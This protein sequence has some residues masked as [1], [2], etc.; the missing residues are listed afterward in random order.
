MSDPNSPTADGASEGSVSSF[1]DRTART[2]A[3]IEEL[4]RVVSE[5][6]SLH[7]GRKFSPDGH[8]VGSIGEAAAEAMFDLE[9]KP[10]SNKGFDAVAADGRTVEIKA[11]F[12]TSGVGVRTFSNDVAD[13]LIVLRLMTQP[14]VEHEVVFNGPLHDALRVAGAPGSNGQAQLRLSNLRHIDAQVA[15]DARIPR[16]S[17]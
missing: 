4:M 2:A 12:G 17:R 1:H 13:V 11:T 8:L 14:G 3:L 10:P 7:P 5:L 9:L 15:D 6:E 16:R